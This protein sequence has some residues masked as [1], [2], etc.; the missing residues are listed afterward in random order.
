MRIR[1]CVG[2]HDYGRFLQ[3]LKSWFADDF[4]L[5]D[6]IR[7]TFTHD[8]GVF[9]RW[10]VN[11]L[12][13]AAVSSVGAAFLATFAGYGFAGTRSG[14][15]ACCSAWSSARSWSRPRPWRSRPTCCSA[16]STWSTSPAKADEARDLRW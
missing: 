12:L 5:F 2:P 10:L 8:G 14:V 1:W 3:R 11:T 9:G 4:S 7:R 6:N 15:A 13:Y 16:K